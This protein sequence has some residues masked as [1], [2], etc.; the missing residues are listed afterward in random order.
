MFP[1]ITAALLL[2]APPQA[3]EDS[4]QIQIDVLLAT[5]PAADLARAGC[6]IAPDRSNIQ[7]RVVSPE[8]R[9]TMGKVLQECRAAGRAK[10]LAEP[11]LVVLSGRPAH[12]ISGGQQAVLSAGSG[13]TGPH[14]E[15]KDVGTELDVMAIVL[16]SGR[17]YVELHP[18][19]R[20]VNP[21]KGITT[22]YGFVPGFDEQST[23][24]AVEIEAGQTVFI[25]HP[26]PADTDASKQ[27]GQLILVTPRL[28]AQSGP[29]L[30]PVAT[31]A[32]PALSLSK[33]AA[34]L[35][36]KYQLACRAGDAMAAAKLARA[37]IELDSTCFASKT[38]VGTAVPKK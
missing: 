30:A 11:K 8:E 24:T 32:A 36:E 19:F 7:L 37:A 16:G 2:G 14:V 21:G 26:E 23:Q 28:L 4:Q 5:M 12:F 9:I 38:A 18:R 10:I 17:I 13:D 22:S 20:A 6:K 29:A 34:T 35:V 33:E 1:I 31:Q 3:A 27:C 15:F 25:W